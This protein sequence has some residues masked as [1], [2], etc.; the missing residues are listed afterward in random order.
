[1]KRNAAAIAMTFAFFSLTGISAIAQD[2][3]FDDY[4]KFLMS[5]SDNKNTKKLAIQTTCTNSTGQIT[6]IGEAAYDLCLSEVKNQA[7]QKTMRGQQES[8]NPAVPA[9]GTTIHIGN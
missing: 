7:D 5:G 4:R 6:R 9:V 2:L 3:H 1:M 8:S